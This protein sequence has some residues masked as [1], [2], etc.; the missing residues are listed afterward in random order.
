M[1]R[2]L[3]LA[4]LLLNALYFAWSQGLLTRLGLA[5]ATQTEP[6]HLAQQIQPEAVRLLTPDEQTALLQAPLKPQPPGVAVLPGVCLQVGL[7]DEGQGV[8]LRSLLSASW[9]PG[10]WRLEPAVEPARWIVY[11][12]K[13]TSLED[14]A[15]KRAQLAALNLRWESLTNPSLVPGLSLGGYETQAA[16]NTAL[17]AFSRRGVRTARVVQ[18]RAEVRGLLLRLPATDDALRARL[19][20]LRPMLSGKPVRPCR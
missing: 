5:P 16:A 10:S 4:L 9:P 3:I 14:L 6:Q 12:G 18:E 8:Q 20:Q 1:L 7:F 15:K 17:E 13:F 11:M 2:F 19:D